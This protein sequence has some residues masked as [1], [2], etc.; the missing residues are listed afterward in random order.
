[1]TKKTFSFF[2]MSLLLALLF[3]SCNKGRT[4][5]V[6]GELTFAKDT[7][8]YLEH[9]GLGGVELIDS[10]KL[11]ENGKFSFVQSAPENPEFYQLRVGNNVAVFAVD[12]TETIHVN[13]DAKSF[14][15]TFTVENS[16]INHQ[17]KQIDLLVLDAKKVIA[18]LE[19][20]HTE[21]AIDDIQYLSLLDSVITHCKTQLADIIL[22]N[23]SSAAA[24]YAVFQ[25]IDSYLIF[26]P[27][28]KK[29][30]AMFG[31]VATSWNNYYA[32]T[33]R[34]KHLYDFTMN[35]LKARKQEEIQTAMLENALEAEDN[36]LFDISLSDIRGRNVALSSLKK[37]VV[38]LDFTVYKSKFS[39][40]HNIHLNSLYNKYKSRDFEIYQIS[41][42]SDEH[43]W[44]NTANNLPW[45]A[46]RDPKSVSS[47]VLGLYNIRDVP[48]AFILNK[49]GDVVARIEN[50][51]SLET[52]LA[53][54]L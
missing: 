20:K 8:I 51:A 23:P 53:K 16:I 3:I 5:T 50:Y 47:S 39:P 43:F 31:A 24:Y 1:M 29:D 14:F 52:E 10:A 15:N 17:M 32:R 38:L 26:D 9:R 40:K 36:S 19:Q 33:E 25:K 12:S 44:K 34:A 18:N 45:I 7:M 54:V 6:N 49:A 2:N 28:Q 42:D 13:G 22:A 21:K 35:A 37:K 4:F 27:L 30:Y 46:V 48:T 11:K 41:L